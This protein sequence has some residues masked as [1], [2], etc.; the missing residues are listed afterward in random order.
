MDLEPRRRVDEERE[1]RG[2]RFG[3]AVFAKTVNLSIELLAELDA[4]APRDEAFDELMV[5]ALE[6]AVL[7]PR[8]HVAAEL[9]GLARRISRADHRDLH[10]LFLK[11]R[12][13]ERPFE[14][15][16]ETNVGRDRRLFAGAA[17]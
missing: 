11:E 5:M 10:H 3:K 9:I 17:P 4:D 2:V 6:A 1:A 8:R 15:W 13:A 12:H 16:I 14:D 7:L